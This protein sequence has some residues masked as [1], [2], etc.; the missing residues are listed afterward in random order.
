MASGYWQVVIHPD[1]RHKTAFITK[2]GLYEHVRLAMGL[3]NSPATYQRIMTYVLQNMLWKDVLVY[4][5]DLIIL[6]QTFSSHVAALREVF[7]RFRENN[8]K[9]KPKK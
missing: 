1:D 5:D 4:L 7:K 9:F 8:L 6:G 3:C 2:Y